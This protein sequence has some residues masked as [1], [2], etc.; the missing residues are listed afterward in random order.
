MSDTVHASA[1]AVG[2]R[3]VLIRGVSASG[4]S[5]LLLAVLAARPGIAAL[6]ADDRVA[7]SVVDGRL[8]AAA[9]QGLAGLMEIRGQGIVRRP[10]VSPAAIDLV[11]DLLPLGECPRL[12]QPDQQQTSVEGVVLPRQILPIGAADGAIRLLARMDDL[13]AAGAG[14]RG[15]G[16]AA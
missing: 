1:V 2:D 16:S 9:P 14:N 8:F 7:L 4:K 5:S 11:A 15:R 6:I 13:H 10:F 3:G 12:P